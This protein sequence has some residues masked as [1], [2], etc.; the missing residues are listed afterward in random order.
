MDPIIEPPALALADVADDALQLAQADPVKA[1]ALADLVLAGARDDAHATSVAREAKGLAAKE[2]HDLDGAAVELRESVACAEGAGLAVRAAQARA[3]LSFVLLSRGETDAAL[4]EADRAAAV[5]TGP[6]AA[7]LQIRR[8]LVLQRLGRLDEALAGYQRALPVLRRAGDRQWE[9]RLLTNRGVLHTYR[10]S[11]DAAERD[12][13]RAA[14]LY[15]ELGQTLAGAQVRHNLGFTAAR[16]G[17][18]PSA[19]AWYDDA[20]RSLRELGVV[21]WVG[22]ADRCELLLS[23]RLLTEART[24]AEQA[25]A[26]LHRAGMD[27]DVAEARLTLA[28]AALLQG[29]HATALAVA[30]QA[31]A[32]FVLQERH[33]WAVLA[34]HVALRAEWQGGIRTPELHAK[35]VDVA[36]ALAAAGWMPA[37]VDAR[38]LAARTALELDRVDAAERDVSA[39]RSARGHGPVEI[40]A[41]AWH[42]EALLRLA[43]GNRRG[44][45]AALRAGMRAVDRHRATLGAAE[46]RVRVSGHVGE[47]ATLG[48]RLALESRDPWRVLR[49]A[50]RWRAGALLPVP[51]R[52]PLDEQ[53][54]ADLAALREVVAQIDEA[55]LAGRNTHRL[56]QRQVSLERAVQARSR[57]APGTASTGE[58]AAGAIDRIGEALGDRALVEMVRLGDDL[59]AV[60]VADGRA[61]LCQLGDQRVAASELERLRF[62][63]RRLANPRGSGAARDAARRSAAISAEQLDEQ[64]LGPVRRDVVDRPLVVVPSGALHAL[65]WSL[66]P[67]CRRRPVSVVPSA[68]LWL[69]ATARARAPGHRVVL[70]GCSSPPHA[71]AEVTALHRHYTQASRLLGAHATVDAVTDAIDG[72]DLAHL[73]CHGS[74]RS[75]NPLFSSLHLADGP[76]TVY[77]L[78]RLARP[79]PLLVLSACDSGLSDVHPGDELMGFAAALLCMGTATLIASVVPVPDAATRRLMVAFH[80]RLRAGHPP[81]L[82]LALAADE[83]ETGDAPA[84][85]SGFVC[86]GAG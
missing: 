19:L 10:S 72:A 34:R 64:L 55:A 58:A 52:P 43:R 41:R 32:S 81:A 23:A 45:D 71:I 29:D 57:H 48:V 20:E 39:V 42:A 53:L 28:N 44:A 69:G 60:V 59:H 46:L 67:S 31:H 3:N 17:D 74:F 15:E 16:R 68:A 38:L 33:P 36:G 6:E 66:L 25:V 84:T 22:V 61:R 37:S 83:A 73:A 85:G 18:L 40:R 78:E 76:L 54:T 9:A 5:L 7:R 56:L 35:A 51:V 1:T 12:L 8:A 13:R 75:E 62:A 70:V 30:G 26:E 86:L 49:W 2:L 63:L 82:S 27:A 24:L 79:P 21:G 80:D 11:F 14:Q 77:D 4:Q 47:L 65:P 50:E